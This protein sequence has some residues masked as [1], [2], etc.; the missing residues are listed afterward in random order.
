MSE[1]AFSESYLALLREFEGFSAAP[2]LCPTGHVTIGYGTNLEA[3]PRHI[4]YPAVR[5]R[6]GS[7]LVGAR[8]LAALNAAGGL[9][10][11]RERAEA[12]M[13]EELAQVHDALLQ[14]CPAYQAL[15]RRGEAARAEALLDMAYNMGVG[16]APS[17]RRKGC[18]L[19]SFTSTLG[20]LE[21]GEYATAAELMCGSLWF[22]QVG[23]R[24]RCVV[25]CI[26]RGAWPPV[27][28]LR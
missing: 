25:A 27:E 7:G 6:V 15:L 10:W 21:R 18:G 14:R 19:L 24:A 3:H 16:R 12:A 22:R 20:R 4:P 28:S 1:P 13:R 9:R 17:E 26:Q 8:L 5:A 23:R 2:Y 11:N